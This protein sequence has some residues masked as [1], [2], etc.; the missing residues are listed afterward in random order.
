MRPSSG[1][2][3][4]DGTDLYYE[5]GGSGPPV[6]LLHGGWLH[7]RQW[8]EQ[9]EA[10]FADH[11]VV[12]YDV[13]GYGRTPLGDR[14]YR[15]NEDLAAL[16]HA[17]GVDAAHFVALSMGSEVALDHALTNP[18]AVRSLFIGAHPMPGYDLGPTFNEPFRAIARAGAAGDKAL[19]RRLLWDFPPLRVAGGIPEVRRRLERMFVNEY[20]WAHV[21][22]DVPP[23]LPV[24]PLASGRLHEIVPPTAV[25]VGNGEMDVL[26]GQADYMLA[27]IPGSRKLVVEGAGHIVNME[28]PET[29][30]ELLLRWLQEH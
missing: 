13:R 22:S 28:R 16:L 5:T 8:D 17:L 4:V 7:L 19:L 25:V 6:V 12:R 23:R 3:G 1:V 21:R 18:G 20:T 2:I 26:L 30:T 15:H 14:P 24:E 9:A 27:R 10:L 29:Y 11:F